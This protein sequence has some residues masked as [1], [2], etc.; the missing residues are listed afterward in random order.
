MLEEL[1]VD[2]FGYQS[3]ADGSDNAGGEFIF[4]ILS[5]HFAYVNLYVVVENHPLNC[6]GKRIAAASSQTRNCQHKLLFKY[7]VRRR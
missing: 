7:G 3:D 6:E 5:I 2:A 1:K 4:L